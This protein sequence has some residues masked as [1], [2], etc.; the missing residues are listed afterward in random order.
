MLK[1]VSLNKRKRTDEVDLWVKATNAP[2]KKHFS[3]SSENFSNE[4]DEI[5]QF[6]K[7]IGISKPDELNELPIQTMINRFKNFDSGSIESQFIDSLGDFFI[8]LS[9]LIPSENT[10]QRIQPLFTYYINAITTHLACTEK[11]PGAHIFKSK[12]LEYLHQGLDKGIHFFNVLNEEYQA[13]FVQ[14]LLSSNDISANALDH[15]VCIDPFKS[16]LNQ[17]HPDHCTL[18]QQAKSSM[19]VT[20]ELLRCGL[21]K[22]KDFIAENPFI[23]HMFDYRIFCENEIEDLSIFISNL[24]KKDDIPGTQQVIDILKNIDDEAIIK[25]I[26]EH[27]PAMYCLLPIRWQENLTIAIAAISHKEYE[28]CY[29]Y[30]SSHKNANFIPN[31]ILNDRQSMQ[32]ILETNPFTAVYFFRYAF[33]DSK[34]FPFDNI[35]QKTCLQLLIDSLKTIINEIDRFIN[36]DHKMKD[37]SYIGPNDEEHH[38]DN[39][40][41]K[42]SNPN[43]YEERI[44]P[45]EYGTSTYAM[46]LYKLTKILTDLSINKLIDNFDDISNID[47]IGIPLE[48]IF[49]ST[50]E[51]C[52]VCFEDVFDIL[53]ESNPEKPVT[54][55]DLIVK[56][57]EQ[58]IAAL[59]TKTVTNCT[60]VSNL[61]GH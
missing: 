2:S 3:Q 28:Y 43:R 51:N 53:K 23:D 60:A 27:N 50:G 15:L 18:S 19:A 49:D 17:L 45:M 22:I 56:K 55:K 34:L 40:N 39:I 20:Q 44:E 42:F 12:E 47:L 52:E 30:Q 21:F 7:S 38:N 11:E 29:A 16:H 46:C 41:I 31:K 14:D 24:L 13:S 6:L 58:I 33:D 61:V 26:I 8:Q 4:K 35:D 9:Y 36:P 1:I 48:F 37:L 5:Q 57:L 54:A 10:Q 59:R 32:D 25:S